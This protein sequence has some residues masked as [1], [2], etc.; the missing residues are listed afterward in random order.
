MTEPDP[1]ASRLSMSPST[2]VYTLTDGIWTRS[3]SHEV[4]IYSQQNHPEPT[5]ALLPF[6]YRAL[7]TLLQSGLEKEDI[8]SVARLGIEGIERLWKIWEREG[9]EGMNSLL[10]PIKGLDSS[11]LEASLLDMSR[12]SVSLLS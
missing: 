9:K 4:P 1:G 5:K 11:V 2:S 8:I 7:E 6:Q 10:N 3:P 12:K